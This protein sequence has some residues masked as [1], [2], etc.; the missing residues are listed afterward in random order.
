MIQILHV[1]DS[2][3]AHAI[4]M[5]LFR[6]KSSEY[7]VDWATNISAA[8]KM[9]VEKQ[10]DLILLDYMLPD[11]TGLDLLEKTKGTPVVFFTGQ[12]NEK[13]AVQAMKQGAYDYVT[14]DLDGVYMDI[15]P[16]VIER[17]LQAARL[18]K[19]KKEAEE[20]LRQRNAELY[21]AKNMA[22][23]ANRAKSEFLANMS[24]E[25]RTPLNAIMGFSELIKDG[26]AGPV[27]PKEKEYANYILESGNH[28]LNIINEVLDLSR[29]DAGK[30]KLEI[31]EFSL[32]VL[33]KESLMMFNEEAIK[34]NIKLTTDVAG[35][36]GN[37][38]ADARKIKQ[39]VINLLSNAIKF[40]TDSA[41]IGIKASK[42][43]DGVIVTVWDTGIGIRDEDMHRLFMPFVQLENPL[44]K[45]YAGMGLGLAIS[46]KFVELHKGRIWVKSEF[47]S[48]SQVTFIIPKV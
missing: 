13:V 16:V 47:G 20:D 44:V 34:H 37:I 48:G 40:T 18:K 21:A 8:I 12:G 22:E 30:A 7:A 35:D 41:E 33:L 45:K 24:H 19:E 15:L 23:T 17:T 10:Y 46:K 14:K 11:G 2:S 5:Q 32:E 27:T 42:A 31:T 43:D 36:I 6:G 39:V 29:L 26:S 3:V 1:E 25:L 28:L 38:K 9:L 4:V